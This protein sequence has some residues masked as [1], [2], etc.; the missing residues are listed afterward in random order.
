MYEYPL[1]VWE[2]PNARL[3]PDELPVPTV[4]DVPYASDRCSIH[5]GPFENQPCQY[6][7]V[8]GTLRDDLAFPISLRES[9]KTIKFPIDGRIVF[10]NTVN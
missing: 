1:P 5:T 4:V 6:G 3:S 2:P 10:R 9:P 7:G 8:S